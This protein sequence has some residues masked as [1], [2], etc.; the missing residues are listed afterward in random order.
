MA[1][2]D[3]LETPLFS[4]DLDLKQGQNNNQSR[5]YK[6]E[7]SNFRSN[8]KSSPSKRLGYGSKPIFTPADVHVDQ[9]DSI[10]LDVD[11]DALECPQIGETL[12][13]YPVE[14]E[15]HVRKD[16]DYGLDPF[17]DSGRY[18]QVSSFKDKVYTRISSLLL[19]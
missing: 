2:D 9:A 17:V 7:E 16:S 4:E 12:R 19:F 15:N 1:K 3:D 14:H 10:V 6:I 18:N 11:S 8:I 5:N 13:Y